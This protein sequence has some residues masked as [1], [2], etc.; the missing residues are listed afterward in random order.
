MSSLFESEQKTTYD[1]TTRPTFPS[2]AKQGLKSAVDL[3]T[4]YADQPFT[5]YGGQRYTDF[6][7]D[8]LSAFDLARNLIGQYQPDIERS[9]DVLRDVTRQGL[10]GIDRSLIDAYA[11][12][13]TEMVMDTRRRRAFQD[14]E[15]AKRDL[16]SQKANIGAF[17]GSRT[18]LAEQ[19]MFD[20]F[21]QRLAEEE[22]SMLQDRYRT[23]LGGAQN[24]L[25]RAQQGAVDLGNLSSLG[26]R[27]GLQDVQSL[28]GIGGQ[29]RALEQAGLD[30]A[31]EQWLK[32]QMD[33]LTRAS[34]LMSV[35]QPAAS[36]TRGE[37]GYG[38]QTTTDTP[39]PIDMVGQAVKMTAGLGGMGSSLGLFGGGGAGGLSSGALNMGASGPMFMMPSASGSYNLSYL[40]NQGLPNFD[41]NKGGLVNS[42]NEGGPVGLSSLL[43]YLTE[44]DE[45]LSNTINRGRGNVDRFFDKM[46]LDKAKT[47]LDTLGGISGLGLGALEG[48]GKRAVGTAEMADYL[49]DTSIG[50]LA[51]K[52]RQAGETRFN[53]AMRQASNILKGAGRAPLEAYGGLIDAG[54]RGIQEIDAFFTEPAIIA[55]QEAKDR[56]K[57]KGLIDMAE[58]HMTGD[59]GE[60]TLTLEPGLEDVDS[61]IQDFENIGRT[62]PTGMGQQQQQQQLPTT[63]TASSGYDELLKQIRNKAMPQ[64]GGK[65]RSVFEDPLFNWGLALVQGRDPVS[66]YKG[67]AGEK[68]SEEAAPISKE[69]AIRDLARDQLRAETYQ[70]QIEAQK[71]NLPTQE[72]R[73]AELDLIKSQAA[74]NYA[75]SMA[76]GDRTR[77]D[78]VAAWQKALENIDSATLQ[79][80]DLLQKEL[81]SKALNVALQFNI[82]PKKVAE[83]A[84]ILN[85]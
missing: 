5:P 29:Q 69:A 28:S 52:G 38:S 10:E 72:E 33:P 71:A 17:G 49:V 54:G 41:F 12:P 23:A 68:R 20:R 53:K 37:F 73:Q 14:L 2:W 50:A 46:D 81:A 63:P 32:E 4:Q 6:T 26:Q 43:N 78:V 15:R 8:E 66:A 70:Q 24:S 61:L 9:S 16:S 45:S 47:R 76:A 36:L 31:Y 44:L 80:P 77:S 19:E 67:M 7:E 30:F 13:Y 58:G 57:S 64:G 56:A 65:K 39:S 27:L 79:N 62:E 60:R 1:S 48:L 40:R 74:K 59:A 75:Q 18:G 83:Y 22:A 42:Y 82:P 3:A 51:P 25:L 11:N 55:E 21:G 34:G 85:N 84:G 35:V